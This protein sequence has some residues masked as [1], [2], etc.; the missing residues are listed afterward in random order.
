MKRSLI[1]LLVLLVIGSCKRKVKEDNMIERTDPHSFS[2]PK[3]AVVKHLDLAIDVDFN[4]QQI[5][6][7]ATW[8]ID[9]LNKGTEIV[10]D[11][12]NLTVSKVTLG[13]E[14]KKTTFHNGPKEEYL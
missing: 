4:N 5:I 3:S 1:A 7:K 12:N 2:T 6:G 11:N 10:F 13:K 8:T 14:E 9:N